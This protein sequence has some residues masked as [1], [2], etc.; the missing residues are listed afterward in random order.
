MGTLKQIATKVVSAK[1]DIALK[2]SNTK[3]SFALELKSPSGTLATVGIPVLAGET[4]ADVKVNGK[5]IWKAGKP[6]GT[7]AGVN[8]IEATSRYL[9]FAVKPGVWSFTAQKNSVSASALP[10]K[11]HAFIGSDPRLNKV[12]MVSENGDARQ[13]CR[14]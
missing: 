11:G 8:F 7:I 9:L 10:T 12:V 13:R 5:V 2:L 6:S 1:G 3:N 4:I 14:N